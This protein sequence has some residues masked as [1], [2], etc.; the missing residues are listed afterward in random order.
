MTKPVPDGFHTVTPHLIISGAGRA[1]DWYKKAFG[2]TE[3]MRKPMPDGRLM[4]AEIK[5]GDSIIMMA[6]CFPEYGQKSP[7]EL[8]ASTVVIS[9]YVPDCDKVW[10]QALAV[11]ATVRFPLMDQFWGDRYGQLIDPFGHIW[12]ICTHKEDV[13]PE[14]MERRAAAWAAKAGTP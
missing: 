12:G 1:M 5:I 9:L 2:A 4:H 14:E 13:S 11:G 6:D 3:I 10:N 8:G 7:K